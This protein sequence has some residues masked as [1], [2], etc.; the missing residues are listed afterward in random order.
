MRKNTHP[1]VPAPVHVPAPIDVT[2]YRAVGWRSI[3]LFGLHSLTSLE[4]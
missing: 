4:L 3:A 2:P 1:L